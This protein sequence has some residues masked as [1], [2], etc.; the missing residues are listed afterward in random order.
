MSLTTEDVKKTVEIL[1]D[2]IIKNEV[3]FCE[4]DSAAGD[5]DFGMSLAKGFRE[6]K[7][8]IETIDSSSTQ[9]FLRS[10]S[11][12]ISEF[13]GGASGPIWGSAFAAA[14]NSAK[15]K[16]I[17][18][19]CDVVS[20]FEEASAAIQKR[21]GAKQG[22]KTLLDALIPAAD[23]LKQAEQAGKTMRE[24]MIEAAQ[25]AEEGAEATRNMVA[26]RGRATYVG[27]RSLNYPDA[28][29]AAIGVIFKTMLM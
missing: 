9:K 15:G 8:Q 1:S 7:T 12:I 20:M 24:A 18:E 29:A 6:V 14:A 17:L 19:L 11:M 4:L 5:G 3:Y 21:G 25:K 10:C 23:A 2:I 26:S 22:D 16:E 28:G 27:D 13:C